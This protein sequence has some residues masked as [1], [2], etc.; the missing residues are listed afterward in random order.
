[1][2][3]IIVAQASDPLAA[4]VS[5]K[6]VDQ[7]MIEGTATAKEESHWKVLAG[8]LTYKGMIYFPAV[9]SLCGT[10]ISLFYDN[11]ESSHFGA[12]MTTELV[13]RDFYRPVMN[14]RVRKYV[15]GCE[16]CHRINAPRHARHG[17]NMPPVPLSRP[18]QVVTMDFVT[19]LPQSTASGYSGILVNHLVM[20][21]SALK[22]PSSMN[23]EIK[24]HTVAA[25]LEE[26]HGTLH[27]NLQEA[28]V[29]QTI[30]AGGKV[31]V[32]EVGDEVWLA[33]W[34]VRTTRSS[35]ELDPKRTGPYTVS[36]VINKNAF[37]LDLP[38]TIRTHNVF[39]VPL[40]A[41]CKSS[42]AGEPPFEPQQMVV[43]DSDKWE[44]DRILDSKRRY[45]MLHHHIQWAGNS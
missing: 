36:Q 14:S 37:K 33:T 31:V 38:Y 23:S 21:F 13:S 25:G 15:S 9:D 43:D 40:L 26:T 12:L 1:M 35:K 4:D 5:A 18:W 41:Q 22:Q 7:P 8:V 39:H 44:D 17:I 34:R 20:Q 2:L 19:D 24:A 32:F 3:A 27:K 16:V 42:P 30:H 29:N 45:R 28:Q 11:P 6:L 10:E